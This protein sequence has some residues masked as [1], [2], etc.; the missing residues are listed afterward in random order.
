MSYPVVE[1]GFVQYFEN[2]VSP[3]NV[4]NQQDG[5]KEVEDVVGWEHLGEK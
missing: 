3:D 5:E 1:N 2:V 4:Q